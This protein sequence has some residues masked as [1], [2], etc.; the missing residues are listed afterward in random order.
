MIF[1][2]EIVVASLTYIS[3]YFLQDQGVDHIHG[4]TASGAPPQ[5]E[6]PEIEG[7]DI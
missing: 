5:D 3:V 7:T 4:G 6:L 2:L 1:I